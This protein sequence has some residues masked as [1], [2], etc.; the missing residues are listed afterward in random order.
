MLACPSACRRTPSGSRCSAN[1]LLRWGTEEQKQRFLPRILSGEDLVPGLLRARCRLRPGLAAAPAPTLDG[2]EWVINGQKVWTSGRTTP[3]GSS[4]WPAP[5]ATAPRHQRHLLPAGA[6]GPARH[7][8]A[9]VP[10]DERPADFNEVFFTDATTRADLVVGDVTTA[11]RWRRACWASSGA[12]RPP[13]TPSSSRPSWTGW[14]SSPACTEGP[15]PRHPAADRLVLVEGRIMR[16]LGYR[17]LTGWLKG[18]AP[19]PE[20]SIS[21]LFWSEYPSR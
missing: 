20:T 5:T 13:P 7:R 9:P 12:R 10:D 15:G 19:G 21:K 2:D 17:V 6:P 11:G 3:T 16:Y 14:S 1:T 4:C 8:G 18:A